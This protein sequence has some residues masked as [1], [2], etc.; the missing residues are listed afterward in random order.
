[1]PFPTFLVL[2]LHGLV[3]WTPVSNGTITQEE[4]KTEIETETETEN[5]I[6]IET[7]KENAPE[8]ERGS[9]I[10][11]PRRVFSTGMFSVQ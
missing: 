9:V 11:V 4:R 7:E 2:L 5:E 8:R 3:L 6:V 1:M 10:I